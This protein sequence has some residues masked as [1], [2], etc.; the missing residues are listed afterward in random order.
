[1]FVSF[2]LDNDYNLKNDVC[3]N[4]DQYL[5]LLLLM[6][7]AKLP[8]SPIIRFQGSLAAVLHSKQCNN[9]QTELTR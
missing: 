7:A 5:S 6:I 9:L 3:E 1:M 2:R 8:R 4:F